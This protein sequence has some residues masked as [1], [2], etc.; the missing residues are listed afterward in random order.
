MYTFFI[1]TGTS[2]L[3][4]TAALV[5]YVNF[6]PVLVDQTFFAVSK[7]AAISLRD[8]ITVSIRRSGW[9][10]PDPIAT[11]LKSALSLPLT[12]QVG[13]SFSASA[14][15]SLLQGGKFTSAETLTFLCPPG[16]ATGSTLYISMVAKDRFGALSRP[17][18][19]TPVTIT[20]ASSSQLAEFLSV[21][22]GASQN[23][24]LYVATLASTG[25]LNDS[26]ILK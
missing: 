8:N 1:T 17:V 3:N 13:Y 4:A 12:Y 14:S 2:T 6:P 10:D 18:F 26:T 24:L 11:S 25:N 15:P 21:A 23:D 19:L 7:T 9:S 5:V 16:G 22:S 20:A